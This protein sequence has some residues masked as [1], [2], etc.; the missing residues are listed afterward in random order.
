MKEV[1][2][3]AWDIVDEKWYNVVGLELKEGKLSA[4]IVEED[5]KIYKSLPNVDC[6]LTQYT[7]KKDKNGVDIYEDDIGR[8]FKANHEL[9]KDMEWTSGYS[10]AVIR[11]NGWGFYFDNI[12]PED[13]EFFYSPDGSR[14]HISDNIKLREYE[15]CEVIG[16][17]YENPEL[18]EE[19]K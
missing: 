7:G 19:L 12:N 2:Y 4:V 10:N 18:L 9:A 15:E 16:N 8:C 11:N 14:F 3:R 13:Y 6:I 1:K 5:G 17:I